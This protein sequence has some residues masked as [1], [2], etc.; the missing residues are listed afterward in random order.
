MYRLFA[1]VLLSAL[2]FSQAAP[3]AKSA[4]AATPQTAQPATPVKPAEKAELPPTAAVITIEGICPGKV[5]A[6]PSAEC[7]TVITRAE[8]EKL[9]DAFDPQ[10]PS[11]RRRQLADAYSRML[12]MSD[13]AE[14]RGI[15][16]TPEAQQILHFTHMQALMQLLGRE[17]QKEAAKV[18]PAD[19]EKYYNEH[20]AQYEQG[21]FQRIFIPKMPASGEKPPDEKTLEAEGQKIRAAAAAGGD[22]EK[23]QQ[24]AFDDL[25]LKTPPPP[26][27][28]GTQRRESLPPSQAKVFDLQPGQTSDV[29]NEP[30]GLYIFK[31][32]SKKKL[33]LD[34]ATP[35]I[36]HVLEQQRMKDAVD[37]LTNSVK[38][39]LN[40]EYFGAPAG[41][42]AMPAGPP[43]AGAPA[44]RLPATP[45]P[46]KPRSP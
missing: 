9:V 6:T 39:E 29:M 11:A 5:P 16:N 17:I 19:T 41:P 20:A 42:G 21:S 7:K 44:R 35:E 2:A 4:P 23:L 12:V 33:T 25:G 30:G 13:V 1:V 40:Q 10:M 26:T 46:P 43:G 28:T 15:Q 3:P 22:F 8:F 18:P 37:K 32:D 14:Q 31:L 24:Q 36:N 45:P 27:A 38:P 34:E